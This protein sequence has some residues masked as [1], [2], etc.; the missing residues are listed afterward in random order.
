MN[1]K[2]DIEG[3]F[4]IDENRYCNTKLSFKCATSESDYIRILRL[5]DGEPKT[6]QEIYPSIKAPFADEVVALAK[7]GYLQKCTKEKYVYHLIGPMSGRIYTRYRKVWYYTTDKGR[8]LVDRVLMVEDYKKVEEKTSETKTAVDSVEAKN[9]DRVDTACKVLQII[10]DSK[11]PVS[12]H[13]VNAVVDLIRNEKTTKLELE[14]AIA[15]L[16]RVNRL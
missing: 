4:D 15:K 5:C 6:L 2:H 13:M 10:R 8:E 9:E 12:A 14:A 16:Q 3:F 7:Q 1:N 11:Q